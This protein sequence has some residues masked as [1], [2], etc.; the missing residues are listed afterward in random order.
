MTSHVRKGALVAIDPRTGAELMIWTF[1][2]NPET[3]IRQILPIRPGGEKEQQ[4]GASRPGDP[5]CEEVY[6][7]FEL[8]AADDLERGKPGAAG[9]G[10]LPV[11]S[12]LELLVDGDPT[13]RE[14]KAEEKHGISGAPVLLFVWGEHRRAPVRIAA[15]TITEEAFDAD[16]V[17]MRARIELAL[18]VLTYGDSPA[19]HPGRRLFREYLQARDR[20]ATLYRPPSGAITQRP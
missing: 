9:L 7:G 16:L 19:S 20:L 11:L 14:S 12:A 3:L 10:L 18:Q 1:Q 15:C 5:P 17:P 6:L 8:D 13:D 2:Y 4:P